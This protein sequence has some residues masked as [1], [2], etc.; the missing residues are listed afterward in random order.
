VY[1]CPAYVGGYSWTVI[2]TKLFADVSS[3]AL[4]NARLLLSAVSVTNQLWS[5]QTTLGL[6]IVSPLILFSAIASW[7]VQT[8]VI[9]SWWT[10][11]TSWNNRDFPGGNGDYEL[12]ENPCGTWN[13]LLA[14]ETKSSTSSSSFVFSGA[15]YDGML[16]GKYA[17]VY[18]PLYRVPQQRGS[19]CVNAENPTGCIDYQV[20]F[21]CSNGGGNS[22]PLALSSWNI[23]SSS[24][25]WA[26]VV[27]DG[28]LPNT[29][30]IPRWTPWALLHMFHLIS[31]GTTI[32]TDTIS[33]L[34]T[35]DIVNTTPNLV[36]LRAYYF[37]GLTSLGIKEC[38]YS[39]GSYICPSSISVPLWSLVT[40]E[41]RWNIP[42]YASWS[43]TLLLSS[44]IAK[45]QLWTPQPVIWLAS[46]MSP[47]ITF[48]LE[49]T[50]TF[51]NQVRTLTH[52]IGTGYLDV[53]WTV[54]QTGDDAPTDLLS[55]TWTL[56][57]EILTSFSTPWINKDTPNGNWDYELPIDPCWSGNAVTTVLVKDTS[58]S[59]IFSYTWE[60]Y[61][62]MIF[63]KYAHVYGPL[64]TRSH[65]R[66]AFCVNADNDTGCINYQV[67]F[68]CMGTPPLSVWVKKMEVK[69][70]EVK[71]MEVKKIDPTD[72]TLQSPV[73]AFVRKMAPV[74]LDW[75]WTLPLVKTWSL[76]TFFTP[77]M[78]KD[79]PA[80]NW[81]YEL[82]IAPCGNWNTAISV[83][84]RKWNSSS[85]FSYTWVKYDGVVFGKYIHIYGPLFAR[86]QERGAF[87]VNS[88][89]SG[90]CSDYQVRF[91]CAKN[92]Q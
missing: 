63:G 8:W 19:F 32:Y 16:F 29:L 82:P 14:I 10:F 62:G 77:W 21:I 6:P 91:M 45:N 9:G 25:T 51:V 83:L 55:Q 1:T 50:G 74:V 54:D 34:Y 48:P 47:L 13:T 76:S 60:K 36:D 3:S 80:G 52:Q 41:I 70:M 49:G 73:S 44:L 35:G 15:S 38:S 78:N 28:N 12:F 4:W 59:R 66:W 24:F 43:A 23:V 39:F 85:S 64:F 37:I 69:K 31:T 79:K 92:A 81:D 56:P 11:V 17:H 87:C 5:P 90:G 30:L 58:S 33:L 65:E 26:L 46:A 57:A 18:G 67:S 86:S 27:Q 7:G 68:L 84:V 22:L 89:N 40:T 53:T 2:T 75:T 88:D 42:Y 61:D 20:R 72:L 71:K